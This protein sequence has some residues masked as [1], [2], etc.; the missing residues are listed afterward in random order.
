MARSLVE[1][2]VRSEQFPAQAGNAAGI[3]SFL[4]LSFGDRPLQGRVMPALV[5]RRHVRE[6]LE[7]LTD[8]KPKAKKKT[9]RLRTVIVVG[10]V[11]MAA[12]AVVR[13]RLSAG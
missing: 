7:Q 5:V 8:Q 10:V 3:A 4:A 9:H 2:V 6:A 12:V 13:R 1:D 11:A